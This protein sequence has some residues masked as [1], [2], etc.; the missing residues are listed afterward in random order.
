LEILQTPRSRLLRDSGPCIVRK[1]PFLYGARSEIWY[2]Q[3]H[4]DMTLSTPDRCPCAIRIR[5]F[6]LPYGLF[7]TT[8][9]HESRSGRCSRL[10]TASY[11][12]HRHVTQLLRRVTLSR[13]DVCGGLRVYSLALKSQTWVAGCRLAET[14]ITKNTECLSVH[15]S[16]LFILYTQD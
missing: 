11:S 4:N 8:Q 15:N 13:G 16:R 1:S 7:F 14:A 5:T 2:R 12:P 3:H 10:G 6:E 9:G